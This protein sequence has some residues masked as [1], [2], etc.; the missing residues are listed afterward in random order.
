V[1]IALW[2]LAGKRAGKPLYEMLGGGRNG[3]AAYASLPR[4]GNGDVAAELACRAVSEGYRHIK[5]HEVEPGIIV[6]QL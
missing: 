4:Y 2:D 6:Y 1:D 3:L 5:V